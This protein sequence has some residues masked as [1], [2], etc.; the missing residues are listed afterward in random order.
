MN[1]L[2]TNDDGIQSD[3]IVRLARCAKKF[4]NVYVIAPDG[5]RSANSHRI[6]LRE[7]IIVR[8]VNFPVEGVKAYETTGTPA[9]CVRFGD[10]NF[11][12]GKT[13]LVLS[14]I[15]DGYN[16]GSDLQYS[17]TA[18][19]AL[20]AA[21]NGI[22]AIALSENINGTNEVTTAYLEEILSE[23]IAKPLEH[24][25]IWNVNFPACKLSELKGILRDRRVAKKSFYVDEYLENKLPDGSIE[26]R[27]NGIIKGIPEEGTDFEAISNN[28]I[29]IGIVNNLK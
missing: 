29:S 22:Q 4:G 2:I 5:Q 16:C 1:I 10:P 15:N 26:L 28:Y 18:G 25:Q 23:L 11:L 3:G 21:S 19:A 9:D 12:G 7:H 6:T 20:E 14:G 8:E 27:V 17:A 24:N 13:D